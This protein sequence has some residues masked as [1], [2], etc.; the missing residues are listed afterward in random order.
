MPMPLVR[1]HGVDDVRLD[2]V[3]IPPVGD[4]DVLLE[5]ELCGICGSD[6]GYIA[7]GG[8]VQPMPLGHELVG[9]IKTAGA[10]VAGF[11]KGDRV[12]VN[13][14]AAGNSIGNGG[15]E[16]GFAP[17]LLVRGVAGNTDALY[18]VPDTLSADQAALVEPLSVALHGCHQGAVNA[19]DKVVVLG[20]GPIGLGT[21]A[22]LRW[23]GV[24]QVI[25]VDPSPFRRERAAQLGA[26]PFD[27]SSGE[28]DPFLREH[29][30]S[31]DLMGMP[32]PA[33]DVYIEATGVGAVFE[34]C[35]NTA[36][37]GARIV[38]V[39]LHK[40]P[41]NLDLTNVL[42]RELQIVG[43]MAYP[44]EFPAVIDMLKSGSI[45]TALLVSH[46]YPL[47]DFPRALQQAREA[48]R[49]AK[50]LVDCQA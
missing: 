16:G 7:M 2:V 14:M 17:Y 45:D 27:P 23:L 29:H 9:T 22:C 8:L 49:A 38:V 50:V 3:E 32:V 34:Q 43:S 1:V 33:T 10:N 18:P 40:Q 4:D 31:S 13:P 28:L 11:T 42:L 5:V 36:R 47:S 35:I 24:E 37:Q 15:P 12:V 6:L 26:T 25:A 20:A 21:I 39:G 30:G 19:T 46:H 41:V 48:D 44:N